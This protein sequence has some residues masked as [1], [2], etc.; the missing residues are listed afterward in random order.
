MLWNQFHATRPLLWQS[1][2]LQNRFTIMSLGKDIFPLWICRNCKKFYLPRWWGWCPYEE[3]WKEW[4]KQLR[5]RCDVVS[6]WYVLF[7]HANCEKQWSAHKWS[8]ITCIRP[9][10]IEREREREAEM[11]V[12]RIMCIYIYI[13]ILYIGSCNWSWTLQPFV[14]EC[15]PNIQD[16]FVVSGKGHGFHP[17]LCE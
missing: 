6:A 5:T 4:K 9:L 17:R 3:T 1:Q 13:Y 15:V 8:Y 12:H 14:L 7:Q 2:E 10:S 16:V 11:Y